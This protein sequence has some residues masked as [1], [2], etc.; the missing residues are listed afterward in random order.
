MRS[1]HIRT[2]GLVV[3]LIAVLGMAS[4]AAGESL[5]DQQIGRQIE[6]R[7]SED[8]FSNVNVSVQA[9]V[10]S[11]SGTVPSLWAKEAAF[12]KARELADVTSVVTDAL[13]IERAESDRAIVEQIAKD[14][15]RVSIPGPGGGARHG[16]STAPGITGASGAALAGT[17]RIFGTARDFGFGHGRFGDGFGHPGSHFGLDHFDHHDLDADIDGCEFESFNG[18]RHL[19]GVRAHGFGIDGDASLDFRHHLGGVGPHA[20]ADIE[21][22]I[23]GHT[24]N[25]FYGI[26]DY[27]D[28][29]I[30]D[31]VVTL[32]GYVTHEYKAGQMV[33][34][35][36]RVQGVR[37]I[38]NQIDVLPTSSF[39]DQLRASLARHIY[40]DV[41]TPHT[42]IA[43][44]VHIIVD[45]LRVTLAGTVFS[46]VEKRQAEHVARQTFGVLSVQNNLEVQGKTRSEG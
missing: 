18:I 21:E 44:P 8:A 9:S 35:V 15:W 13:D 22:A 46:E 37:E 40:G 10:V 4:I 43:A 28:G 17:E 41:L 7:L 19:R 20:G 30:D 5:T 45:N 39:D 32:T 1:H 33:E 34:L 42:R 11:L 26:F 38:Q 24:S 36:S 6:R 12:A 2:F 16:V 27:V 31:G 25:S 14:I 3:G 29:G 23:Y